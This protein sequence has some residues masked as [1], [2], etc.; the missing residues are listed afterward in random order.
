MESTLA[1]Q[2]LLHSCEILFGSQLTISREFLDYLQPSGLKGAYRKRAMETHP[3]RLV[4]RQDR[5]PPQMS[6]LSFHIVQEAYEHL[7]CFLKAREAGRLRA[8]S[9]APD[10]AASS[11]RQ[12]KTQ[13]HPSGNGGPQRP[14]FRQ[15]VKP[16]AFAH[17]PLKGFTDIE[18]LYQGP[19]PHRH[20]RFGHFL[21]YS[22]LISWRTIACI[23]TWQR[24]ERPRLG[25]LGHRL[26]MLT[27]EDIAFILRNKASFQPFGQAAKRLGMLNEYQLRI[28]IAQQQ[29]LQKKFGT[30]L[31][32]KNIVDQ[33][34]LQNLLY[35]FEQ[36]NATVNGCRGI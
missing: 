12:Q 4:G 34:E 19:L 23:L 10:A 33:F 3:D 22:G 7:L 9:R 13:G 25:E 1:E 28:L 29:R 17:K 2:Q 35:K 18:S 36:H 26:G 21:Y 27:P 5:M 24:I 16:A 31:L 20:L 6:A 30:I 14:P 11:V 8:G 15:R 32:E